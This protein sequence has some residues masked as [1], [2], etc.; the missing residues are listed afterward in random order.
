M[1]DRTR[2][3]EGSGAN[4]LGTA[5]DVDLRRDACRCVLGRVAV[6]FGR[7]KGRVEDFVAIDDEEDRSQRASRRQWVD[8]ELVDASAKQ[9]DSH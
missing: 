5:A 7:G 9:R 2:E 3:A 4:E 8:I 6:D 1:K